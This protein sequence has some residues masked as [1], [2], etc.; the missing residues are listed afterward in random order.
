MPTDALDR[1]RTQF[2]RHAGHHAT[3]D[4]EPWRWFHQML[5]AAGD[6]PDRVAMACDA[7]LMR[8]ER[9]LIRSRL[10]SARIRRWRCGLRWQANPGGF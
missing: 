10:G 7:A 5:V 8:P 4:Q 2:V 6:E 1:I 9:A 3:I